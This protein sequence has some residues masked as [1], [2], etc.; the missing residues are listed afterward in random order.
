MSDAGDSGAGGN[1]RRVWITG[2][3][4]GIGR[5]LTLALAKAGD[6]IAASARS[7]EAL[8]QLADEAKSMPG[9]IHAFPLDVTDA[10]AVAATADAIARD[11][12]GIDLAVLNAGT[13]HPVEARDFKADEFEALLEVNLLGTARCLEQLLE[14]MIA[15]KSG[16]IA[17]VASVAGYSGLPTASYYGSSKAALINLAECLRFDLAPLG[18]KLQLIDPGFVETPLT[19]KNDFT[20]PF[21]IDVETAAS[22]IVAGLEKNVFEIHFP[23]RFTYLLK[24]LGF[25]PYGWYFPLVARATGRRGDDR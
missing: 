25:L 15:R 13:H 21:L 17:I 22:R 3:S 2:A 8:E 23:R 11:L 6:R 4:S 5:A 16:H 24:L 9:S 10:E 1:P 7:E 12:G 19:D 14:P 20:M 18:V